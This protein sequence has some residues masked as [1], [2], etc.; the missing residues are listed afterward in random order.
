MNDDKLV[1]MLEFVRLGAVLGRVGG[2]DADLNWKEVLSNGEQQR[3]AFAGKSR[4][5]GSEE[6]D[7]LTR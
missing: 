3:V 6:R 5:K 1:E 4:E 7:G 2:L